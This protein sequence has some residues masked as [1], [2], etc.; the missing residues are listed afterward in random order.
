M[1]PTPLK[2][3]VKSALLSLWGISCSALLACSPMYAGGGSDT[4]VS[5]KIV[6]PGGRGLSGVQVML[7]RNDYDPAFG[8]QVPASDIETTDTSGAYRFANVSAGTYDIQAADPASGARLLLGNVGVVRGAATVVVGSDSLRKPVHLLVNL[9]DSIA[10]MQGY[11][12]ARGTTVYQRKNA[13]DTSLFFDSVA[14]GTIPALMFETSASSPGV[15]LFTNATIGPFDTTTLNP[16]PGWLHSAKLL[17]NTSISGVILTTPATDFVLAVRLSAATFPFSQARHGGADIRF[18]TAAGKPVPF[19]I[20][21]WDSANS[22]AVV[23]VGLDTVLPNS[24]DQFVRMFWG[25]AT[26]SSASNPQAVFDTARGYA[27][28][29]HFEESQAGVGTAGL[30]KDATPDAANGDDSV[31]STA[32]AS[33]VGNAASFAAPDKIVVSRTVADLAAEAFTICVWVNFSAPG[34]VVFSKSKTGVT[35]DTGDKELWFGDS[36]ATGAPGLRP[37]FGGIG[38]GT[39]TAQ[40]DMG[41]DQWH[42]YS[43]RW[44]PAAAAFF[45]DGGLCGFTGSYTPQAADDPADKFIIGSDGTHYLSG[46]ID[47]LHVSRTART[48]DWIMLAFE[49]QRQDQHLVTI[50]IEK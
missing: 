6:T 31:A 18:T 9:P 14:Q 34:G 13:G 15:R 29:W 8:G 50:E 30:Y 17:V 37:T 41:V 3:I 39:L 5:G 26:A 2:R 47:E 23:W 24:A 40:R 48:D 38:Q 12:V 35:A 11:I 45:I 28:V 33:W 20:A 21:Q 4:E 42:F 25:N 1:F 43:L 49:N 22:Q 10:A 19:E 46:A 36:A 44:K 32:Q 16:F 27:G 7:L